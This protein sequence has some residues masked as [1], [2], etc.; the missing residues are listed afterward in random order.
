MEP[1]SVFDRLSAQLQDD[2][3]RRIL[4]SIR[5]SMREHATPLADESSESPPASVDQQLKSLSVWRRLILFV[6]QIFR[7]AARDDVVRGW[8]LRD[9]ETAVHRD[10]GDGIDGRRHLF[11]APFA[12]DIATLHEAA[13][14][15]EPTIR[16][17]TNYRKELVLILATDLFP[18]VHQELMH[19]TSSDQIVQLDEPS[20][21][22]MKRSLS[23]TL[24][25]RIEQ[26]PPDA[27]SAMRRAMS[28]ADSFVK[29]V[30][31]GYETMV[32]SFERSQ[33][34]AA[35]CA[36]DYL[37][38][39]LTDLYH[40]LVQLRE[41][42][43]LNLLESLAL[44][45]DS[46]SS[47]GGDDADPEAVQSAIRTR[48]SAMF[49]S[50]DEFRSF[51]ARYP[52]L[53]VLRIIKQD[54]WWSVEATTAGEDWI[55]IYRAHFTER[56]QRQVLHVTLQNQLRLRLDELADAC[57]GAVQHF[58]GL[59]DGRNGVS[60][61][62][63]FLGAALECM[64]GV[65]WNYAMPSLRIV[66]TTGE[67]YKSSNRAQ[68]ND[69]YNEF[70]TLAGKIDQLKTDLAPGQAWGSMISAEADPADRSKM[71]ARIDQ[72]ILTLADQARTT[73]EMIVNVL[74]GILY[75]RPGSS[76][77]TLANYGQIGGRRNAE[78]VEELRDLHR[79]LSLYLA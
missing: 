53:E 16:G 55:G 13:Q 6:L 32:T 52:L 68:F 5:E 3:R 9:L 69:A 23:E 1:V 40:V 2:D 73:I 61:T 4:A 24:D 62:H 58:P 7:G 15:L 44:L 72:E 10:G 38:R 25:D 12:E 65:L 66:L 42:L 43:N 26:I 28:Q 45:A 37:E 39:Q 63:W 74:G 35:W 21:R 34:H 67:F 47:E 46:L 20:E 75:A 17:V 19:K 79:R 22:M 77:D 41:P 27:R 8:M 11:L 50:F 76:Y 71:A 70:E 56:I 49:A 18:S 57:G 51:M 54:P 36:F 29:L 59:P 33:E 48:L 30:S 60:T 31:V 14:H 64:A 78:F